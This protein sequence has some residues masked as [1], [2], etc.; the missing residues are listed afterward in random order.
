MSLSSRPTVRRIGA[1]RSG[2]RVEALKCRGKR[3]PRPGKCVEKILHRPQ[4]EHVTTR[5]HPT[6]RTTYQGHVSPPHEVPPARGRMGGPRG[7]D[8]THQA[9]VRIGGGLRS[10]NGI[11][12]ITLEKPAEASK[13]KNNYRMLT[14]PVHSESGTS[15]LRCASAAKALASAPFTRSWVAC[16]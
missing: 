3:C 12:T 4:R 11:G 10:G 13:R 9:P 7:A 8:E 14:S 5:A 16:A 2:D 1:R 6:L 15:H